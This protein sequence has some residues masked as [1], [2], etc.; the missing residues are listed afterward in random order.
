MRHL[1]LCRYQEYV[2]EYRDKYD[3]YCSLNRILESFRYHKNSSSSSFYKEPFVLLFA[4][5]GL[6]LLGLLSNYICTLD[7]VCR[8]KFHK[9]GKDL[10]SAKGRDMDRYHNILVQLKE[11]YSQCGMV[12]Y[13]V[14]L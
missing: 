7:V 11:S 8:N 13:K 9:L 5:F 10:E 1:L 14:F 4:R 6:V 3:S 2:Q 12:C